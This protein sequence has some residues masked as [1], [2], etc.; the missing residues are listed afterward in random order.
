MQPVNSIEE[1]LRRLVPPALSEEGQFR[2]EETVDRLAGVQSEGE[3]SSSSR[4]EARVFVWPWKAVA[5]VA[6]LAIPVIMIQSYD[7]EDTDRSLAQV[8]LPISVDQSS[9]MI[10]QKVWPQ[11]MLLLRSTKLIDAQVDDG[12]IVPVNGSAPHYRYRYRVVDEERVRD[13]ETG[14]VVTLRQPRQEVVTIPVT[15][16]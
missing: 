13:L 15:Q 16:F 3:S 2:L 7:P 10:S 5:V 1:K 14:I 6:A 11:E 12:L 9:Q 8:E 4:S